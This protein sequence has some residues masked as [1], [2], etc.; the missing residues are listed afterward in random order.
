MMILLYLVHMYFDSDSRASAF[1]YTVLNKLQIRL[2][3]V[4]S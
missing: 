4:S 2:Y 1:G 3:C